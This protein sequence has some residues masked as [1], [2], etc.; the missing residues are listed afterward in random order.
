L[1]QKLS[2]A[3]NISLASLQRFVTAFWLSE[4][5][6]M[7]DIK[8]LIR[9]LAIKT[10][11]PLHPITSLSGG[12]Q[13]KVVLAKGLLTAPQV[14]LLDEPTR[15]IDVGAKAEIFEI[16]NRLAD[17]G[18]A[19]LFVSSELPEMFI[20]PDRVL[21]LSKGKVTGEFAHDQVTEE[22]LVAAASGR[23]Q[24]ESPTAAHQPN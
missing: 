11:S 10:R 19:V 22:V 14:L 8:G 9:D 16:M 20:I 7:E 17:Q 13:Q 18:L 4:R 15:G 23:Q 1:I 3:H 12:N 5:R 2:V 24:T 21:V 6:E